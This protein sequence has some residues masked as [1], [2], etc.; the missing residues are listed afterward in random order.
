MLK[1]ILILLGA[2]LVTYLLLVMM[3]YTQ[4]LRS[5]GI[6]VG[7]YE[8]HLAYTNLLATGELK[9]NGF[10]KPY[11]YTNAVTIGGTQYQC[12]IGIELGQFQ[13]AGFL[14][15]TTNQYFVFFDNRR[16]PIIIPGT[17]RY[18]ARFFP[19]GM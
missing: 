7:R 13:G 12:A 19:G 5:Y 1:W 6:V 14:T 2:G 18:R 8:L 11:L 17:G 4:S 3:S 15:I 10:V 9:A 16:G